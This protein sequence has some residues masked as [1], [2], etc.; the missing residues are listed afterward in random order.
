MPGA[1]AEAGSSVPAFPPTLPRLVL[2]AHPNSKVGDGALHQEF[3][4]LI[5]VTPF[6]FGAVTLSALPL[7]PALTPRRRAAKR[8][9]GPQ[10]N[11]DPNTNTDLTT[12]HHS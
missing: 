11:A 5:H 10:A 12:R 7:R 4:N 6:S 9:Q 1:E 2:G 8:S 3:S